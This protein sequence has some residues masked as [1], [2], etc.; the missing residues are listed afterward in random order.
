MSNTLNLHQIVGDALT[1]VNAWQTMKFTK[2]TVKWEVTSRDPV[3][4]TET[5]ELKG[6]MQPASTQDIE[7]LGYDSNTYQYFKIYLTGTPTQLDRVR[8]LGSDTFECNGMVYRITGKMPWDDAGWRKAF[9]Y[10]DSEVENVNPDDPDNPVNP[11]DPVDPD[12]P[13]GGGG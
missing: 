7:A 13:N 8:Q 4:T 3:V 6:K 1:C 11:D 5:I 10:L 9:C 2:S 12:D